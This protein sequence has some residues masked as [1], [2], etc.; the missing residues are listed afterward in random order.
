[1]TGNGMTF[2]TFLESTFTRVIHDITAG[3]RR[4]AAGR[5]R[6]GVKIRTLTRGGSECC[7]LILIIN[8]W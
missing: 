7:I 1:M 5:I 2:K 4:R 8:S 6:R 3:G